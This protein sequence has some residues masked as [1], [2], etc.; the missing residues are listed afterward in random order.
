MTRGRKSSELRTVVAATVI[1]VLMG[2]YG[3]Y[4]GADL[5]A[6]GVLIGVVVS[7]L[8]IFYPAARTIVKSTRGEQDV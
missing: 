6:L 2:M 7:P 5:A 4:T 3:I 1:G 8:S